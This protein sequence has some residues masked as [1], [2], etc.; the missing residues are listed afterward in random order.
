[1]VKALAINSSPNMNK[2]NTA[3]LLT[4]FIEGMTKAG[5]KV[6]LL[7]TKKLKINP[8]QGEYACVMKTPGKCFQNDDMQMLIPKLGE[9]DIWV[10]AS[11][12]YWENVPGP[13]KNLIDRTVPLMF[14]ALE[15]RDGH[16]RYPVREGVKHG[17][18]VLVSTC[19]WWEMDNFDLMVAQMKGLCKNLEREFAGALL[20]PH[21]ALKEMVEMGMPLD[22]IFEAAKNA[23]RQLV[24]EDKM[25]TE[26]LTNI[27]RE[28]VTLEMFVEFAKQE[29]QRMMEEAEGK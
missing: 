9:A 13:M 25:S 29:A 15:L 11:P 14:P 12:V 20:R 10:F 2:G 5:A 3:M 24:E 18:L 27:S 19:G 22:D 21:G 8:C 1:M 26:N 23:G 4:P 28:L 6:E 7:Y 16:C 17:K